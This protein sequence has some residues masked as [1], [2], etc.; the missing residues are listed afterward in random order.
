[1]GTTASN[2][3]ENGQQAPQGGQ[4]AAG[5]GMGGQAAGGGPGILAGQMGYGGTR[6]TG[7][8]GP[9][10]FHPRPDNSMI[11]MPQGQRQV[12]PTP[13][14]Q[15]TETIRNDV[16]LK[17][18]TLR[19]LK[20]AEEPSK[21]RLDF[22][23][24]AATACT[25]SIWY[26]A[27]EKTDNS[28]NTLSFETQYQIQPQTIKFEQA[29]GQRYVQAPEF[30]FDVSLVQN[31]GQM[32]YH[33]GSQHFPVIIMLQTCEDNRNRV[34]SQSTFATFKSNGDGTLSIGVVKQKIQVQGNA[35][36][37][38]E[39]YGIEQGQNDAENSK[40]CVICMSA[41]KD[42]TV[43]PCRHM[44]MCSDCAKVL[45]YQTNKCP[46]CRCSVESLLQI[47]VNSTPEAS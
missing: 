45:R 26:L 39:I 18:Q 3:G 42:T 32:Y 12:P 19:L 25:V 14:L 44:C 46:I 47:K 20:S 22:I 41:P 31:R 17:K 38:Q 27:E 37:L 10:L 21:Y 43:L 5:A 6:L 29:L 9:G 16:N 40:E 8:S 7:G 15:L 4:G 13:Q 1:M 11:F 2:T 24:D 33:Q 30:A 23:F 35:Y 36:E 28:N 34:Q